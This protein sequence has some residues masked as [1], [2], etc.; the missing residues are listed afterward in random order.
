MTAR[1][2]PMT[3]A[4]WR[5]AGRWVAVL[6]VTYPALYLA[7]L[8]ALALLAT[9]GMSDPWRNFPLGDALVWLL[10]VIA[11][12]AV[13]IGLASSSR[14]AA[15]GAVLLS[16]AALLT[17]AELFAPH[18]GFLFTIMAPGAPLPAAVVLGVVLFTWSD[19]R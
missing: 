4:R 2:T 18:W 9:A 13:A 1:S 5:R 6:G 12:G 10:V 3:D 8:G 19:Y 14:L 17:W 7:G 16:L 15:V 11:Y